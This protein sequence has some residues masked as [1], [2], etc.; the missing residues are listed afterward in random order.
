MA[1]NLAI[2]RP[3]VSPDMPRYTVHVHRAAGLLHAS[4]KPRLATTPL[5]F[6]NPL[7]PSAWIKSFHLQ[8]VGDARHTK[9]DRQR[10]VPSP[11]HPDPVTKGRRAAGVD[12]LSNLQLCHKH[13]GLLGAATFSALDGGTQMLFFEGKP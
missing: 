1:V 7:P 9:K 10:G 4:F 2:L 8:A 13:R 5:R 11:T 3:L 12:L 6:A